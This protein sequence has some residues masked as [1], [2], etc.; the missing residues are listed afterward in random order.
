MLLDLGHIRGQQ[1]VKQD[2]FYLVKTLRKEKGFKV[3][4]KALIFIE[5]MYYLFKN[6]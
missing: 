2:K 1:G 4:G 6:A 5:S 3:R